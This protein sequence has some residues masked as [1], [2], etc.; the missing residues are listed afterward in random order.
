[1][2][3]E[4]DFSNG[5]LLKETILYKKIEATE[6]RF[7]CRG[8]WCAHEEDHPTSHPKLLM[9]GGMNLKGTY[10]E[11]ITALCPLK[12]RRSD[13]V[14][15]TRPKQETETNSKWK[16]V[17]GSIEVDCVWLITR[18]YPIVRVNFR[19]EFSIFQL[20]S[21]FALICE[22]LNYNRVMG[23]DMCNVARSALGRER[24]LNSAKSTPI[25]A[26]KRRKVVAVDERVHTNDQ[27]YRCIVKTKNVSEV[28]YN[29]KQGTID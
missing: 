25:N 16:V 13:N 29:H 20:R 27:W 4:E 18:L 22:D 17:R 28:D 2:S 14:D 7:T 21:I 9:N 3:R 19:S 26:T 12:Y 24:F 8:E 5:N 10:D 15:L 1:M 6:H 23:F 11:S